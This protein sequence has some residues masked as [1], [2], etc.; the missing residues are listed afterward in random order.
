MQTVTEQEAAR[1]APE[2]FTDEVLCA[3]SSVKE[4][5]LNSTL[6]IQNDRMMQNSSMDTIDL[7][8][9]IHIVHFKYNLGHT[10]SDG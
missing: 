2:Y 5:G 8:F 4:S 6:A 7:V 1:E 9:T 3:P 10:V